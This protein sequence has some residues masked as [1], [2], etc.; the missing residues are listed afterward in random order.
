M[1]GHRRFTTEARENRAIGA[2]IGVAGL[3]QIAERGRHRLQFD[4]LTLDI[5]KVFG[6]QVMDVAAV[7][8][9]QA[10]RAQCVNL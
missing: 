10:F 8:N 1:A 5:G 9:H 3:E 7:A 4:D 2:G 6:S